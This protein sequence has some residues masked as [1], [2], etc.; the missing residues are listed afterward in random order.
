MRCLSNQKH[1]AEYHI[2]LQIAQE[3]ARLMIEDGILS[4]QLAKQKAANRFGALCATRGLPGNDEIDDAMQQYQ[5]IFADSKQQSWL[6]HQRAIALEAM[7]FLSA[8]SPRLTG[9]VLIGVAGKHSPVIL[10]AYAETPETIMTTL[11]DA[12]IPFTEKT[13]EVTSAQGKQEEYSRLC[14][15]VD[16]VAVELYLF[17]EKQRRNRLKTKGL[18][19]AHATI[20]QVRKLLEK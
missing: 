3:A 9:P 16:D 7:E 5:L 1:S 20:K 10:R 2:R 17:P 11:L 6:T 13:H 19:T 12:N 15:R 18:L 4:Y 8:F 14:F